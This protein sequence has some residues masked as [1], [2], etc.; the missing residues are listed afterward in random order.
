MDARGRR[1]RRG[2]SARGRGTPPLLQPSPPRDPP[3]V[4]E[5]THIPAG[6]VMNMTRSFQRTSEA[7]ISR[8]DQENRDALAPAE[9]LQQPPKESAQRE[10]EKVKF[11]K[12][13]GTPNG[14]V[15]EAW[16]ENISMM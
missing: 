7:L 4:E 11:S 8:L 2:R 3:A 16:L 6:E 5:P 12:F 9:G 10:L 13:W 14:I 1:G 15:A